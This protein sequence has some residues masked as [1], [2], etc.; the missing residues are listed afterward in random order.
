MINWTQARQSLLGNRPA[1]TLPP[2]VKLPVLPLAVTKFSQK[3]EEPEASPRELG[4]IIETDSGL[5]TELL[6]YVN[7][8]AMGLA[9]KASSGAHA[10]AMLGIR[11]TKLHLMTT[12]LQRMMKK[13]ESKLLNIDN[14]WAANL[15]RA[16]L[17]REVARLL[18]ADCDLAFAGG[19]LQ[20]F[21]LPAVTNELFP[22]YYQFTKDQADASVNLVD[23]ERKTFQW[24]HAETG[25]HVMFNWG[26]PDELLCCVL[27][28]HRGLTLLADKQFGRTA[29][30]A[31]AVSALMPGPLRQ[32]H[33][34]IA[35]LIRLES[36]WPQFDLL[37]IATRVDEQ[38]QLM[39]P[40]PP[41][42]FSFL[43]LC[44]KSLVGAR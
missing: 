36:A 7:S 24:D 17:A 10:I 31:I 44:Q 26:F 33:D 40:G 16:I 43:R 5:T 19:M 4:A 37:A 21:L 28:H 3:A 9:Q 23:F 6:K 41:N 39:S 13:R 18:R 34:G 32:V 1:S 15:E 11:E 27:L 12:A 8:A 29:A 22:A 25:A 14:F 30:A 38:Y 35:Q 42:P 20:D 2:R